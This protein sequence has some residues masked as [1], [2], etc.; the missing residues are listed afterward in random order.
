M[1]ESVFRSDLPALTTASHQHQRPVDG[2]RMT[3]LAAE[4]QPAAG[5]GGPLVLVQSISAVA[6][7]DLCCIAPGKQQPDHRQPKCS[8]PF[9]SESAS[10]AVGFCRIPHSPGCST[11]VSGCQSLREDAAYGS[12][13]LCCR[14]C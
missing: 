8:L 14:S 4:R 13:A 10:L 5:I 6:L 2:A 7:M 3:A 9:R 11:L 1:R 12:A